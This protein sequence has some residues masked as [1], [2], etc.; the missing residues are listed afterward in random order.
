MPAGPF[1]V[2]GDLDPSRAL[3]KSIKSIDNWPTYGRST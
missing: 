1:C 3:L 2:R